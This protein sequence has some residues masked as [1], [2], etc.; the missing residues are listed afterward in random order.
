MEYVFF[1]RANG[2]GKSTFSQTVPCFIRVTR[3]KIIILV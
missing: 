3:I 2:S 1:A